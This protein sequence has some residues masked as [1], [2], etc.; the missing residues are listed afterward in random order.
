MTK[1]K[2][3]KAKRALL[4]AWGAQLSALQYHK[5]TDEISAYGRNIA[6]PINAR[7]NID[8]H[9]YGRYTV[10]RCGYCGK[11]ETIHGESL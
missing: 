1:T 5:A 4:N 11:W 8:R 6:P 9:G 7:G 10:A 3:N 2:V